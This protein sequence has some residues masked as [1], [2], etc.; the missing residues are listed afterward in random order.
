MHE[1]FTN[2]FAPISKIKEAF[3]VKAILFVWRMKPNKS[4]TMK[5]KIEGK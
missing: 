4:A 3:V 1:H 2:I 5:V